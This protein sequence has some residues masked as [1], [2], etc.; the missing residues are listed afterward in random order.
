MT[1]NVVEVMIKKENHQEA[2]DGIQRRAGT[3]KKEYRSQLQGVP[4]MREFDT[5]SKQTLIKCGL[6]TT[7]FY[8]NFVKFF[9][10]KYSIIWYY[11]V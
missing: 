1:G 5:Q 4:G 11:V 3:G 9:V 2:A 10:F 8:R 6:T 7:F